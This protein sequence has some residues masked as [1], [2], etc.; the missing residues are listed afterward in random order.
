MDEAFDSTP[1]K[2]ARTYYRLSSEYL[3]MIQELN[4]AL[5]RASH[6]PA[7]LPE[8]KELV[9]QASTALA[10]YQAKQTLQPSYDE[11]IR[12]FSGHEIVQA[13]G[14]VLSM[15]EVEKW[16]RRCDSHWTVYPDELSPDVVR[17]ELEY[18]GVAA[19]ADET[20]ALKAYLDPE[21]ENGLSAIY[22]ISFPGGLCI[23]DFHIDDS[24]RVGGE[25][26]KTS[27]MENTWVRT[28]PELRQVLDDLC[29]I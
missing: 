9:Q 15:A 18:V 10:R 2:S 14:T 12:T 13:E 26:R 25:L 27:K 4:K 24:R 6:F 5:V 17:N 23:H 1:P 22:L 7:L 3:G 28:V 11:A 16:L 21:S 19:K 29:T 8:L 20:L